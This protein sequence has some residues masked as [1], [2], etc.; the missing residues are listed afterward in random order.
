MKQQLS[1]QQP[2]GLALQ[3]DELIPPRQSIP[4]SFRREE[5]E[6]SLSYPSCQKIGFNFHKAAEPLVKVLEL[7]LRRKMIKPVE[8]LVDAEADC[9]QWQQDRSQQQLGKET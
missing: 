3:W 1:K 7:S 6:R 9:L 4:Q 5:W 8:E 2:E